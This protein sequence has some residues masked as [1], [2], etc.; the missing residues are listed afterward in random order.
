MRGMSIGEERM[1][2][3]K[4]N[5]TGNPNATSNRIPTMISLALRAVTKEKTLD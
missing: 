5:I 3:V 2:L 1:R 4:G